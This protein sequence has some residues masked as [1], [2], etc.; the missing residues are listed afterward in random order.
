MAIKQTGDIAAQRLSSEQLSCEFADIAPL[1]DPT[2]AAAA[3]SRCHYCYDA[4]CVQACPT[5]ID[6]PSFIR[7]IGN[8][9]LKGAATD[10]LS[11]N[12]L[13][14]M[15]SRVCPTEILCE[16]ACV[17]NHQDAKPVAIG[18]LQRH[19][20]DWAMARDA[21]KFTRAPDSGRHVAVVGAGPA[22]LACAHRLAVAGHRVTIY[23]AHDKGGGLN[24]Y[25]I[26][27]YKTV[28]DFAQREV[29]WLLSVG[30][31]E[32]KTGVKLGHD[33]S[34]DSLRQQHDAVFLSIGL[35]GVRA[36][37]LEG[38]ALNG[39]MNAVDFIE[40]VRQ[41]SDLATVPV[42]RRVI[43]IGGGN[44]AVDAAVQS[45]KLGATSVTMVYRRGVESMSA[46]WAE[47]DFAQTQNVTLITH[48]KPVRLVGSDG[49]VTGVEFERTA[50]DG[51]AERFTLEA[52]MVLKAIG[53]TLVTVGLDHELLTLD[54]S[55]IAVDADL[56]TSLDKVWAGGDCAASG[57]VDLTVQAVQDGKLAA[58]SIDAAFAL[59]A[60]KAA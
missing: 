41:A 58:A 7:K 1:L 47:R 3:A 11:A 8:G 30:G 50:S 18:A 33:V 26:A 23:D 20:T 56:R 57:G 32:L 48:A 44:T 13:G 5:Q 46:T 36:L 4:P 22:G 21:V 27:A 12:P 25:G 59:A 28:D 31:I 40:Q 6:I 14:G 15:C 49:V 55:R 24:E 42:G 29:Q 2:A 45:R 19:A 43:V 52:D 53:Q 16:G 35:A 17:R 37:A 38:E 10:I 39:V 34:L 54:Q 51:S 60:V 9:N